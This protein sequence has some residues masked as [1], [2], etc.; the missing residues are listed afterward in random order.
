MASPSR[1]RRRREEDKRLPRCPDCNA[2]ARVLRH[3]GAVLQMAYQH[4]PSC[5]WMTR[6]AGLSGHITFVVIKGA[7]GR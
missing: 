3:D 7:P 4:E 1:S 2:R 6:H 5:P